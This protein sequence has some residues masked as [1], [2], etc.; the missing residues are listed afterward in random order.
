MNKFC[1]NC[2]AELHENADFC[3][4]CGVAV[5]KTNTIQNTASPK[6][7]GKG[8]GVASLVLGISS[9]L[10]GMFSLFIFM[11]LLIEG[12]FFY[13]EEKLI[14]GFFFLFTPTVLS[15]IGLPLGISSRNKNKNG[16]NLTGIILNLITLSICVLGFISLFII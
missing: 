13:F 14:F 16:I 12:E 7:E 11:C 5:R 8:C 6:Q 2:G 3:V 9:L 1:T 10:Q 15:I 4:K